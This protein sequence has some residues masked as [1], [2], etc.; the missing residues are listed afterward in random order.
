MLVK[1]NVSDGV[2]GARIAAKVGVAGAQ[3]VA[4]VQQVAGYQF[5]AFF[6]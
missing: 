3:Q 4:G 5:K 1:N 2:K 6:R